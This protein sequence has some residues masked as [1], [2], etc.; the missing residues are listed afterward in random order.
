MHE[1]IY[2]NY[3]DGRPAMQITSGLRALSFCTNFNQRCQ[4]DQKL[5]VNTALT[6]NSTLF[7]IPTRPLEI[8]EVFDSGIVVPSPFYISSISRNGNSGIIVRGSNPFG[9]KRILPQWAGVIMEVLPASTYNTGLYISN[10][11][12][13][14]AI[15]N[16]AKLMTCQYAG[17]VTVNGQMKLPVS[18]VPFARWSANGVSVG[19]DGTNIIVR[20]SSYSGRDDVAASVTMELA[21]FNNT[22]PVAGNGITMTNSQG[23]VTFSTV[24]KPFIFDK[25]I[26]L[27]TRD[28]DIGDR[29]IQLGFYGMRNVYNGGYDHVRYNGIRMLNNKVRAERNKVIGNYRAQSLR[30]PERNIVIPTPI[31]AIPN[32]Y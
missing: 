23:Q 17:R 7:V 30:P 24:K 16:N 3:N 11:T 5:T 32:M 31:V 10:S 29:L 15:S 26:T 8:I 9:Y 21:I 1:G 28:Q 2:I 12:D 22:P 18:G 14:T 13:F 20:N 25:T 4:S 6:P 27:T 19:F